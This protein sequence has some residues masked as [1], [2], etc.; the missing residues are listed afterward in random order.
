[1]A[2]VGGPGT[3]PL[4]PASI[5]NFRLARVFPPD[6]HRVAA[7]GRL[8]RPS[9]GPG[10]DF[11]RPSGHGLLLRVAGWSIRGGR[12]TGSPRCPGTAPHGGGCSVRERV[13]QGGARTC[14]AGADAG[15]KFSSA[16]ANSSCNGKA[17]G[18]NS[19]T[20]RTVT[21]TLPASL[22]NRERM[23]S[24]RAPARSVPRNRTRRGMDT[25]I[26][27]NGQS[28]CSFILFSFSPRP[29]TVDCYFGAI[30]EYSLGP[31]TGKVHLGDA[32]DHA[33]EVLPGAPVGGFD[34]APADQRG[35]PRTVW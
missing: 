32:L 35:R 22:S 11:G 28:C 2:R 20:R 7:F 31:D 1:M 25:R 23:V 21:R 29:Q 13:R 19:H 6:R 8:G 5:T 14:A 9:A 33:G 27:A 12:C 16:C 4:K 10:P 3:G 18:K 26:P 30:E 34:M 17:D 15:R 24:M